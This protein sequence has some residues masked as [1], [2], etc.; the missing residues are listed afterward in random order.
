MALESS[1]WTRERVRALP[2]DGKRYELVGGVL[3][4]TPGP[5]GRHQ[6]VLGLLFLAIGAYVRQ[7]GLGRAIW[8]P[9]ELEFGDED[10]TQPDLFVVPG[11]PPPP[12]GWVGAEARLII[13][14]LSPSSHVFDRGVK[15]RLAQQHRVAEYWVVDV[16]ARAVERWTP[17][18]EAPDIIR[19]GLTWHPTGAP[20]PLRIYLPGLFAEALG[21]TASG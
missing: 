17:A 6:S 10:L 9:G 14:A 1:R 19:A 12:Q 15:R 7:H 21:E 3:L 5:S 20:E 11:G 13:E 4:V 18:D 8:G 16:A 2:D